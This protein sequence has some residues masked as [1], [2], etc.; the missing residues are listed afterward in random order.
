MSLKKIKTIKIG[1][2]DV[3]INHVRQEKLEGQL[4]LYRRDGDGIQIDIASETTPPQETVNSFIHEL[5]HSI[6]DQYDL[7]SEEEEHYVTVL[8]N[9][10]TGLMRDNPEL[11]KELL[12][13]LK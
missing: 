3:P 1:Y 6:W 5:F 4:G 2:S 13:N 10:F 7:P 11:F 8:A 12:R 9:G